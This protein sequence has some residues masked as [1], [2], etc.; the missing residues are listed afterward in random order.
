[1]KTP[2]ELLTGHGFS[3]EAIQHIVNQNNIV[4]WEWKP[5]NG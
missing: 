5:I 3:K 1:M 2:T 4:T